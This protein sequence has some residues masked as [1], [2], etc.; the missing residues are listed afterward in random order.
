MKRLIAV[1]VLFFWYVHVVSADGGLCVQPS[2]TLVVFGNG[3]LG[4]EAK[5]EFAKERL[6]TVLGASLT[7][8]EFNRLEFGVAYNHSY[9]YLS[10]L[11]ESLK[12]KMSQDNVVESFWR[13]LGNTQFVPQV[14][15]D[16]ALRIAS[17]FDFSTQVGTN[18]LDIHLQTYRSSVLAGKTVVVVAHSQGN[19]F[20][21][22]AYNVLY[23]GVTP[24]PA[25]SF[26]IVSVANP[27]SFVGGG[28]PY[29]T[30]LEDLV[31]AAVARVPGVVPPLL[32]NVSNINSG[33]V[34]T[35]WLGHSITGEYLVD[36][37]RTQPKIVADTEGMIV[38]LT[39][40]PTSSPGIITATPS[41]VISGSSSTIA[42][43][44]CGVNHCTVTNSTT[45]AILA[46]GDA[47]GVGQFFGSASSGP[48]IQQTIFA[49]NCTADS[50]PV[51]SRVIVNV[52]PVFGEF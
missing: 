46:D 47:D 51:S 29:T 8:D 40:P 39:A 52:T 17:A 30:A 33:A 12:Q 5:A 7:A 38:G 28:G 27:A 31:I 26:G 3:I 50:S 41:R 4:T 24:I 20:A 42:W 23:N 36:E 21:N 34:I 25:N 16:E 1:F 10:D 48:I 11:Y 9:G 6:K 19:F 35:D 49:I 32:P 13:W 15:R 45:S 18:D 2:G 37:S 22:A 14:V 43:H 44:V